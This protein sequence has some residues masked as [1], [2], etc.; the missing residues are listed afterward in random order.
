MTQPQQNEA[1]L[2]EKIYR[3]SLRKINDIYYVPPGVDGSLG[4]T[5]KQLDQIMQLITAHTSNAVRQAQAEARIDELLKMP[6]YET[7]GGS[8][9]FGYE[10]LFRDNRI[11][12]LK[13]SVKDGGK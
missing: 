7:H 3:I 8:E 1:E 11:A 4:L 12:T 13:Q 9:V 6:F 5:N 2:R 10:R